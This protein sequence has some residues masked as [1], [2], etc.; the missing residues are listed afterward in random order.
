MKMSIRAMAKFDAIVTSVRHRLSYSYEGLLLAPPGWADQALLYGM[1]KQMFMR[2]GGDEEVLRDSRDQLVVLRDFIIAGDD[3]DSPLNTSES[4][5]FEETVRQAEADFDREYQDHEWQPLV[6]RLVLDIKLAFPAVDR[7]EEAI[8][9]LSPL[10]ESLEAKSLV[11]SV[12]EPVSLETADPHNLSFAQELSLFQGAE[13][14]LSH[15]L[16]ENEAVSR[17]RDLF[18]NCPAHL[19]G[20]KVR[21][22]GGKKEKH[23]ISFRVRQF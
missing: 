7:H 1:H 19:I 4:R 22:S 5:I 2:V 10:C 13:L 20:T 23:S 15:P 21:L 3:S 18:P 9:I 14:F 17:I 12:I 8:D 6:A 11:P 16:H